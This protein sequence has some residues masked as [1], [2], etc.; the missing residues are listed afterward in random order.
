MVQ[1]HKIRGYGQF[2]LWSVVELGFFV[3]LFLRRVAPRWAVV[4]TVLT[5]G[6]FIN[7]D[8]LNLQGVLLEVLFDADRGHGREQ[9]VGYPVDPQPR[10]YR[11]GKIPQH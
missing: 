6:Q 1:S 11:Q 7:V 3:H 10:R 5:V 8:F 9:V 4:R 2:A